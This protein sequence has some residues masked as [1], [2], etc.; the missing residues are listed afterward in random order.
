M[1][2]IR[3]GVARAGREFSDG[4]VGAAPENRLTEYIVY[5][6]IC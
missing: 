1:R 2:A 3:R 6:Y 5:G 4:G